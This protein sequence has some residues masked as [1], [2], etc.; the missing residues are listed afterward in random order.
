MGYVRSIYKDELEELLD[1]IRLE[2]QEDKK[3][4]DDSKRF[5]EEFV[6]IFDKHIQEDF[7]HVT[8][9]DIRKNPCVNSNFV[10]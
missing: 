3:I 8:T 1:R 7:T 2:I 9:I 5:L 4:S 10:F 6:Y